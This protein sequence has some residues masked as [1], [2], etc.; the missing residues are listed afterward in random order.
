MGRKRRSG[1]VNSLGYIME[2]DGIS[3]SEIARRSN[4]AIHH[5]SVMRIRD[6]KWMPNV[7]DA[8]TIARVIGKPIEDVFFD[9]EGMEQEEED[10]GATSTS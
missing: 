9:Q 4:G 7:V 10:D 5:S 6:G 8:W 3:S 2:Q 1:W